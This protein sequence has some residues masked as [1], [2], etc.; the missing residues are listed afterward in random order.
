MTQ[1]N[2]NKPLSKQLLQKQKLFQPFD[3]PVIVLAAAL[4]V[5]V[6]WQA[7][8][9][10]ADSLNVVVKGPDKTWIFP[11]EA[12]E[13][14]SVEGSI[15]ETVVEISKGRAAIV[16][17]PCGGQTCVAAGELDKNG[18]WAA[19][20]PN[21]VFILIEGAADADVIDAASW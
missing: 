9:R 15:G 13:R 1:E 16:S 5:I 2:S 17:S 12:E 14:I 4:T 20:L 8:G 11:I 10:G 21:R 3:I 6:G 7:Y 18:Q 19:C